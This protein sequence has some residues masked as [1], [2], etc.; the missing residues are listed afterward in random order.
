M[1]DQIHSA[2]DYNN[3]PVSLQQQIDTLTAR[4]AELEALYKDSQKSL[5]SAQ[6]KYARLE[7]KAQSLEQ[8]LNL[9]QN[10]KGH[11]LLTKY[12]GLA[13]K[14]KA[15]IKS[16]GKFLKNLMNRPKEF[17]RNLK[18]REAKTLTKEECQAVLKSCTRIDILAVGH[19]SYVAKLLQGILH[20]AGI[21]SNV[22][23]Q[24]PDVYENIP[25]IMICPQ[26]F[27]HFPSVYIA[28][29]MEQTVSQRWL[30]DE[31]IKILKN[32]YAI[33]DYSLVNIDYFS[34]DPGLAKK[35]YYVPI[36]LC[37]EMAAQ[38][39]ESTEKEYDVLFY[40]A[41]G[42]ERRQ[43]YLDRIGEF[44]N[45]KI[46][47]D[48]FGDALYAEMK[49]A[50]IIVNIHY[51]ENALLETTRLYETLSVCDSLIISERSSD[52]AE[53]AR[54]EGIVDFVDVDNI[55]AMLDRI[56][57]WLS[58]EEERK[59]KTVANRRVLN[60]RANAAKFFLN[61]FLLANDR[62]TFDEFYTASGD[63]V[64]FSGD[65]I[66]LSLPET[67]ERRAAF[68]LDNRYGFEVIPG[69][70]HNI[71]WVGCGMSYKFIFRKAIEQQL[72]KIL[73]CEDDVFFPPDF[74]E[75]FRKILEYTDTHEDWDVYSGI[76]SDV[77]NMK[78]LFCEEFDGE[79][80]VYLDRMVSM[81]YN[82]YHHNV[83]EAIA[84]WDNTN[85][86]V[87]TNTIDRYLENKDLMILTT[88]PFLVGHKEDL[89]SAVWGTK[90]TRYTDWIINSSKQLNE[91]TEAFKRGETQ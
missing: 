72:D 47:S 58:H 36:D 49:K 90:N 6:V 28:F 79:S 39:C 70:K 88:N 26:N 25:Y 50:K 31:Y 10:S 66:C 64:H 37:S 9:I 17:I 76:M 15:I 46:I 44:Y 60:E 55:D 13:H 7:A 32:A 41:L 81:V 30:T 24:E 63:Y 4:N 89:N 18:R 40:G 57:Y 86:D 19:T 51:Y 74:D 1:N 80:F 52:P 29:Q 61:R 84:N 12:Y 48:C 5:R 45:I 35:L 16:P 62:L 82:L 73:V 87:S 38:H 20:S 11:R 22:F 67:T 69:L 78:V 83:F 21:E 34:K 3:A 14:I 53:D 43:T 71:G 23:F 91:M 65:R 59:L 77:E 8:T 27:K 85:W 75:R 42:N 33:F 56:D 54:L 68:D 2:P